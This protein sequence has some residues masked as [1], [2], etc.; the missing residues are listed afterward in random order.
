MSALSDH[1][2]AKHGM[3]AEKVGVKQ[4]FA[5]GIDTKTDTTT[6]YPIVTAIA[7]TAT[8]D[9]TDEVVVPEGCILGRESQPAYLFDA[10]S[11][12]L[13]HDYKSLPIG[14][15]RNVRLSGGK[16]VVQ[17]ILNGTT[18]IARDVRAMFELGEEN[19]CRGTSIGFIREAGGQPTKEEIAKYGPAA[20]ITR[21]WKWLEH[22]ITPQPCNPDAW[23][24]SAGKSAPPLSEK[25]SSIIDEL[26]CKGIIARE[27]AAVLGL[28]GAGIRSV[29]VTTPDVKPKKK[30]V[31]SMG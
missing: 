13:N 9:L 26:T 3:D 7:N 10:R 6:G 2:A 12:Y 8:I 4:V 27:T 29:A 25:A 20:F 30:L 11:I 24:L 21:T 16:W 22:S 19:P 1:I 14:F 18:D 23:V 31:W 15:L 5:D 28:E 17:V